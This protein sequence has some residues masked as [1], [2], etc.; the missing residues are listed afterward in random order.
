M[1]DNSSSVVQQMQTTVA[2]N[3]KCEQLQIVPL[4]DPE[5]LLMSKDALLSGNLGGI[6][7]WRAFPRAGC[8]HLFNNPNLKKKQIIIMHPVGISNVLRPVDVL[9]YKHD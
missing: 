5:P 4:D 2:Q 3:V 6:L 8:T 1:S 9:S 7:V